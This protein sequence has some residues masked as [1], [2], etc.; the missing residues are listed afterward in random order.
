[1]KLERRDQIEAEILQWISEGVTG[2]PD[3]ERFEHLAVA[4]FELQFR[5]NAAFRSI[6]EAFGCSPGKLTSWREIPPIPT[7]AFKEA[8]LACFPAEQT[9]QVFLTSGS[10]LG[11]R[12]RLELDTTELYEASLLATLGHYLCPDAP[13]EFAVLAPDSA[14]APDSSLSFMFDRAARRFGR[15]P[16]RFYLTPEGWSPGRV[17]ADL[18]EASDPQLV[19]GTAFA[20]VHLI[21]ALAE[22]GQ[23]LRLPAGT[24]VMET[25]GFKGRSRELEREELHRAIAQSL[26]VPL[27]RIVNQYG[28]CELGSQFYEDSLRL[29]HNSNIKHVPPWVRTR[30]VSMETLED[31]EDGEPGV[32]IH[33]D[34]ANT[35]SVTTVQTSDLGRIV[36]GGFEILGRIEGAEARGCSI[37][38]DALLGEARAR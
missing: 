34:L 27:H 15:G 35:G 31:V 24:R 6:S 26:G 38:A 3:E 22:R 19:A 8:R 7:G 30:A 23:T 9:R 29:G 28:M 17:I 36:E 13:I 37:A 10:T 11:A 16:G 32:L 25:G 20:F 12:G 18:A 4:L 1:M 5:E 2:P 33:C 14:Q 21:D